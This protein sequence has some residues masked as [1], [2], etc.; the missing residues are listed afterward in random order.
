MK[1][2]VIQTEPPYIVESWDG[3]GDWC[4]WED[5]NGVT[6][7]MQSTMDDLVIQNAKLTSVNVQLRE[8]SEAL[9][10]EI[11]KEL[12]GVTTKLERALAN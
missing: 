5:V 12:E 9:I 2:Y 1:R 4:R 7:R 6:T 3:S 8:S 10:K 11:D